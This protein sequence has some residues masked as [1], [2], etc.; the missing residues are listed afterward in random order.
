MQKGTSST[1]TKTPKL[2]CPK[3]PTQHVRSLCLQRGCSSPYICAHCEVE[4]SED[5]SLVV[6]PLDSVYDDKA[7]AEYA[8]VLSLDLSPQNIESVK[9]K[10]L[11][12][13]EDIENNFRKTI[14][15]TVKMVGESFER[16]NAEVKRRKNVLRNFDQIKNVS[17]DVT[18][19]KH[20]R[21]LVGR[22]RLVREDYNESL[23]INF[24]SLLSSLKKR[25]T[26]ILDKT[27]SELL[28]GL[29]TSL[30]F[31]SADFS[32]LKIQEIVQIPRSSG[33]GY[34]ALAYIAK[35]N[36]VAYGCKDDRQRS[37]GLYDLGIK[38]TVSSIRFVH[39]DIINNVLWIDD[40]NF[41][42]TGSNDSIIRIFK[43]SEQG[44]K[45][46][47]IHIFRGHTDHVR[48]IKYI[49]DKRIFISAGYDV[50]IKL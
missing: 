46:H 42:L 16:L 29:K 40:E 31:E 43:A 17:K 12:I 6:Q 34:E 30:N 44:R 47:A 15:E 32:K 2:S 24:G 36:V 33:V 49:Q 20:L 28:S 35:W 7:L 18:N 38:K 11:G 48:Y 25:A 5:H 39:Q 21:E 8:E 41:L 14:C 10:M 50:N 37:V 4:H 26:T 13:L 9:D 23:D 19:D 45:L 1:L 27:Q 22:Y 3:H